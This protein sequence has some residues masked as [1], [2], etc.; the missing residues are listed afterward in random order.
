MRG[1]CERIGLLPKCLAITQLLQLLTPQPLGRQLAHLLQETEV[2][3]LSIGRGVGTLKDFD[4]TVLLSV[5]L[6]CPEAK[7]VSGWISFGVAV[8]RSRVGWNQQRLPAIGDTLNQ[9]RVPDR[10]HPCHLPES[11]ARR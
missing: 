6:E 11:M 2:A 3:S 9:S 7:Q 1:S 10:S 8:G 5:V 4:Q